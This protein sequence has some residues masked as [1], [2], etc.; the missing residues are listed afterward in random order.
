MVSYQGLH[1]LFVKP[2]DIKENI[3]MNREG[4]DKTGISRFLLGTCDNV[5]FLTFWFTCNLDF[6]Q[7]ASTY[8]KSDDVSTLYISQARQ[9]EDQ[10]KF[11]EA[12]K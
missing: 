12:E 10:G 1:H 6:L 11:K 9:L 2:L 8:M 5:Y 4:P 3:L 7:M